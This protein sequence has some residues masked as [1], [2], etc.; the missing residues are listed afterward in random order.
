MHKMKNDILVNYYQ[1]EMDYIDQKGWI[2]LFI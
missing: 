1:P 2:E